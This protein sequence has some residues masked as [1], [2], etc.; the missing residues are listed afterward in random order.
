MHPV[1]ITVFA[2]CIAAYCLLRIGLLRPRLRALKAGRQLWRLMSLDFAKLGERGFYLFDGIA[3][4]D[5]SLLGPVLVGPSGVFSLIIRSN[6]PTGR[7]FERIDHL[8]SSTLRLGGRPAFADPLGQARGLGARLARFLD[9]RGLPGVPVT[10]VL[11]FPGWRI[12]KT[13]DPAE[14]DVLV[15]SEKTL[16]A[17]IA[18][19]PDRLEPKEILGLCTVLRAGGASPDT[20]LG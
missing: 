7:I 8:A 19:L 18:S 9:D 2:A 12:G 3:D 13:P 20:P 16:L 17:E 11:I 15:V 10:P 4:A 14:R 5:G 6:P 1:L